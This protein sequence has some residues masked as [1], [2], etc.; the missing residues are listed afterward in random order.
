[1]CDADDSVVVD[2][3]DRLLVS[4]D[5][6]SECGPNWEESTPFPL[7]ELDPPELADHVDVWSVEADCAISMG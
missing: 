7:P 2:E 1:M 3:K 6:N 4:P 5:W